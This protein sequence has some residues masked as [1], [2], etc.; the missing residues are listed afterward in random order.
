MIELYPKIFL[1]EGYSSS[2][3]IDDKVKVLIDAG[4]DLAKPV[5]MLI[6]THIH[7]D[8]IFYAKKIQER[9]GCKIMIGKGDDDMKTLFSHFSTWQGKKIERFSIDKALDESDKISTGSYNLEVIKTPGHTL[10]SISLYERKHGLLFSGDTIFN[11]GFIG[12]TDF[13]HSNEG[14]M[15]KTLSNLKKLKIKM[16]L[17]GH[18]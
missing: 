6:L 3:Y 14:L 2:Y 15:Q 4:A 16:L 13:Y 5:D 17:S 7:P 11:G 12:R 18:N 1:L 10:G 8:H 9:T